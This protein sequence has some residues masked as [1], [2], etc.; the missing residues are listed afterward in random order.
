MLLSSFQTFS[1]DQIDYPEHPIN[2]AANGTKTTTRLALNSEHQN[3]IAFPSMLRQHRK[4]WIG[5]AKTSF[6]TQRDRIHRS[7]TLDEARILEPRLRS[8]HAEDRTNDDETLLSSFLSPGK[9]GH[10][11]SIYGVDGS[12]GMEISSS[13]L[14]VSCGPFPCVAEIGM[15]DDDEIGVVLL[16]VFE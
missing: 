8:S 12:R 11:E 6:N 16:R 13:R 3:P 2:E 10:A 4:Y 5:S 15:L 7:V 14:K 1:C 9:T